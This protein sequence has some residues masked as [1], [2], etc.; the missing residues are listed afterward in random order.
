VAALG[1]GGYAEAQTA[2]APAAGGGSGVVMAVGLVVA[3]LVVIGAAVKIFDLRRKREAEAVYL[4]AQVSDAL[5]RQEDLFG[6]PITATAHV[7]M[8]SG[9]P[10]TI[11]VSGQVP[12]PEVHDRVLRIVLEEVTRTRPD[13]QIEDRIAV[14]PTMAT[15]AA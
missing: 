4:Q 2:A 14:V 3:L 5:L 13:V 6:L 9:T 11:E 1:L 8:W 15:R 12:S 7:P 10:V